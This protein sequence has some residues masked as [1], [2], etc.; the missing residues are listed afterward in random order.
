MVVNNETLMKLIITILFSI[1]SL[2]S[3]SQITYTWR[4]YTKSVLGG[5][6]NYLVGMPSD[7]LTNINKRPVYLMEPGSSETGTGNSTEVLA[8]KYGYA[9]DLTLGLWSG[10][11]TQSDG[12]QDS[13]VYPIYIVAQRTSSTNSAPHNWDKWKKVLDD[14]VT[15]IDLDQVH[16]GGI[17]LGGKNILYFMGNSTDTNY[18][19]WTSI[20]LASPGGFSSQITDSTANFQEYVDKGG[21]VGL[22]TGAGDAS[23]YR[24]SDILPFFNAFVPG[25]AV[26]ENWVSGVNGFTAQSHCCWDTLFK[27][28]RVYTW[29]NNKS[30]YEW[31][32]QFTRAPKAI[33]QTTIYTA[34]SSITLNGVSNGW[35]KTKTWT[36][37]SGPSASITSPNSDTT[38]VSLTGGEGTYVFRMTVTNTHTG[39]TATHDATVNR[40]SSGPGLPIYIYKKRGRKIYAEIE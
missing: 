3:F 12:Y 9:R 19:R 29:A 17:S 6:S 32:A 34:E 28:D 11:V 14:Y 21:K 13:V 10:G 22:S 24:V 33:A 40:T 8:K 4:Y 23:A 36:K 5:T 27:Y 18:H 16:I 35:Y 20:F 25:S 31:Q 7:S 39:V 15:Y 1:F 38:V 30:I 2:V 37:V 26:G